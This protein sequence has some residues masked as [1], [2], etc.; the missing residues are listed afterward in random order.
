MTTAATDPSVTDPNELGATRRGSSDGGARERSAMDRGEIEHGGPSS[1][2]QDQS[3]LVSEIADA[4]GRQANVS[5]V[6]GDPVYQGDVAVIPVASVAWGFGG[7]Q[8]EG[9]AGGS[10]NG[11]DT[12]EAPRRGAARLWGRM[13]RLNAEGGGGG[14]AR[15]QPMGYIVVRNGDAEFRPIRWFPPMLAGFIGALIG[16]RLAGRIKRRRR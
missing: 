3:E 2:R 11:R 12:S 16:A 10:G 1:R 5:T 13:R 7:G 8:R 4:I 14:G 9:T 15:L 6:F